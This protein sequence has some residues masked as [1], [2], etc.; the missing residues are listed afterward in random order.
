VE[1]DESLTVTLSDAADLDVGAAAV[2][3]TIASNDRAP[4]TLDLHAVDHVRPYGVVQSGNLASL[5][6]SDNSRLVLR[7]QLGTSNPQ[8]SMLESRFVL[9][10][11][12]TFLQATLVVEAHHSV[13]TEGDDLLVDWSRNGGPFH[14]LVTVTKTADNGTAQFKV[15]P[16]W[17]TAGDVISL[18]VR[19][20]NRTPGRR[21]LD[22]AS[23]D[24][25]FLR[26][27]VP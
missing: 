1:E 8:N 10:P 9:P 15:L 4:A 16:G 2:G 6:T 17:I 5:R 20:A 25:L 27:L 14:P 13:N 7:E 19:D 22:T 12:P 21:Q 11:L 26:L 3:L 23:L 18:R 24:R